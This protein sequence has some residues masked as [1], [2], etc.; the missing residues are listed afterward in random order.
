MTNRSSTLLAT[1]EVTLFEGQRMRL[2]EDPPLRL[3]VLGNGLLIEDFTDL[4]RGTMSVSADLDGTVRRPTGTAKLLAGQIDLGFQRFDSLDVQ[5]S[6]DGDIIWFEPAVLTI[7]GEE[8]INARGS[9]TLGGAYESRWAP[10]GSAWRT[11]T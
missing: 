2:I 3:K 1:G 5:A 11:S 7:A 6:S 4:A 9:I 8:N 10:P